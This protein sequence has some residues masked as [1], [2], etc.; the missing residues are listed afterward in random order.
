MYFVGSK[1][2]FRALPRDLDPT[3]YMQPQETWG[4]MPA[5]ILCGDFYQLQPVPASSSLLAP[6]KNQSYEHL[7][8]RKLL[9]DME[10]VVDFVD[11]QRFKDPLLLEVLIA[12]RTPGGKT[13]SE[14]SWQALVKTQIKSTSVAA[15]PAG[16]SNSEAE[17]PQ[18]DQRLRA[19][20]GWY[21][22]AYEWRIV[23]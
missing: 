18:Y 19:A 1:S 13:I 8:G 3:K 5:K 23:S 21:E 15:Q 11:M 10:Y 2:C 7:Q 9:A 17:T 4:R 14:D 20:R 12:M 22:S 6:V 16:T